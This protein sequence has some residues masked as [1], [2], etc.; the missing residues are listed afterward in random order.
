MMSFAVPKGTGRIPGYVTVHNSEI[1]ARTHMALRHI[2]QLIPAASG[3]LSPILAGQFPFETDS[4]RANIAYTRNLIKMIEYAPE[5]RADILAL[6]TEKL[7][8][9][10]VQIQIDMED[11][12]D[13]V[14]EDLVQELSAPVNMDDDDDDSDAGSDMSDDDSTDADL[15]RLKA[16]RDNIRKVDCM[17]DE[18]FDFYTPPFLHGT[19]EEKRRALDLLLSHFHNIILPTYRSRHSQFLIFHFSQMSPDLVEQF[20]SSCIQVIL[21]NTST[22]MARQSAAA[23]LASFVARGAHVSASMAREVFQVLSAH[24]NELRRTYEETCR[25]PDLRRYALFYSSAQALLYIFCFRWRDLMIT[26]DEDHDRDLDDLDT[27]EVLFPPSVKETLH[28]AIYSKLNPLKVCSPPIVTE[29]ARL[30]RHLRFLYLF[31]LLEANK[32]LRVSSST[33]RNLSSVLA[34]D[35]R[36]GG[37]GG[38]VEREHRAGDDDVAGLHQL[39]AYFPFDPYQLPRSRRWLEGDYVEWRGIPGL[40]DRDEDDSENSD[41]GDDDDDEHGDDDGDDDDEFTGTDEE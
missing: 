16:V 41:A 7:V 40:D 4:A 34:A 24:V 31:P 10:D 11:L 37:S 12:E 23:Y 3:T 36:F 15:R 14:G 5:L 20:V 9:I 38:L 8:K 18:L 22:V 35:P 2:L 29:F 21:N 26:M 6:V 19:N 32:R 1:Y 33:F 28:R 17:I 25:G 30:A 39:D 13:E 27:R